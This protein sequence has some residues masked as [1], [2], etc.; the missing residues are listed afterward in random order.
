MADNVVLARNTDEA[1]QNEPFCADRGVLALQQHLGSSS[2]STRETG[3]IVEGGIFE[4]G[5]AVLREPRGHRREHRPLA[6]R[7]RGITVFVRDIRDM[8][9]V[10]EVYRASSPRI[11]LPARL[12]LLRRCPWTRSCR[13]RRSSPTVRAPS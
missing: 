3:A 11:F 5:R 12:W 9:V 6:E 8:D 10:D 1:P 13:W 4:Q 2:P 7:R